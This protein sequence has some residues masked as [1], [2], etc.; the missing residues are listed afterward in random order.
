MIQF[1]FSTFVFG[2][3]AYGGTSF[4]ESHYQN[5]RQQGRV[6]VE[7]ND[8]LNQGY[9]SFW[10]EGSFLDPADEEHF[11]TDK[12]EGMHHVSLLITNSDGQRKV[13]RRLNSFNG[14]TWLSVPLWGTNGILTL[15]RNQINYVVETSNDEP[16][17]AGKFMVEVTQPPVKECRPMWIRSANMFDCQMPGYACQQLT[18]ARTE[19]QR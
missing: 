6:H 14:K 11:K 17:E 18:W 9:N 19:C 13:I 3:M 5:I 2:S 16:L 12:R 1:L 7:C 8:G 15:G 10:C 4:T